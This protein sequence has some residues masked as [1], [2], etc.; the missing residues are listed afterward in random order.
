ML[1]L[2]FVADANKHENIIHH[3]TIVESTLM[4]QN[5]HTSIYI[6]II[7][8]IVV[9]YIYI[10]CNCDMGNIHTCKKPRMFYRPKGSS[11][12]VLSSELRGGWWSARSWQTPWRWPHQWRTSARSSLDFTGFHWILGIWYRSNMVNLRTLSTTLLFY[13]A[14]FLKTLW[15]QKES[16][17]LCKSCQ[18]FWISMGYL[19]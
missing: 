12:L 8:S 11:E 17:W 4:H 7:L 3:I 19:W 18:N 16:S 13:F 10:Y 5:D 14:S 6:Y 15:I 2:N 1:N 9:Y